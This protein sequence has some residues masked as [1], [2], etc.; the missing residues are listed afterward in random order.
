MMTPGDVKL[1]IFEL[2]ERIAASEDKTVSVRL[3]VDTARLFK[4][5]LYDFD[6]DMPPRPIMKALGPLVGDIMMN[7]KLHR[8]DDLAD[9]LG[10]LVM[11]L[12]TA[13][14]QQER[15]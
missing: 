13:V 12:T 8:L 7:D 14:A 15:R 1:L 6:P 9:K 10:P 2:E 11:L 3:N 4:D 5:F